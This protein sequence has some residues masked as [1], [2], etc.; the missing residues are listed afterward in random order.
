MLKRRSII[1]RARAD[2]EAGGRLDGKTLGRLHPIW[3]QI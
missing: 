3:P 1:G 2:R